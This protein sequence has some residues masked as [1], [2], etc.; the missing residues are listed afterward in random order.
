MKR[1][2]LVLCCAAA[3]VVLGCG[4]KKDKG[5]KGGKGKGGK[6]KGDKGEPPCEPGPACDCCA[7]GN[8]LGCDCMECQDAVCG[9]D[10]FCCTVGWDSVCDGLASTLCTCC[11]GQDPGECGP[12]CA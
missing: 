8:G 5:D 4:D 7:G 12:G 6:G 10:D 9:A 11:E 1:L 3:L 2:T